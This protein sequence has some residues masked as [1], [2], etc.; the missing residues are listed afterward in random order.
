[1]HYITR[2]EHEKVIETHGVALQEM[3]NTFFSHHTERRAFLRNLELVL[4]RL[5]DVETNGYSPPKQNA[6]PSAKNEESEG[7]GTEQ[8]QRESASTRKRKK[9]KKKK[10]TQKAEYA[11]SKPT[12]VKADKI[13]QMPV[14]QAKKAEKDALVVALLGIGFVEEQI[15]AAVKACGGT[16]RATADDLV[17]WILGQDADGNIKGTEDDE[18]DATNE[19]QRRDVVESTPETVSKPAILPEE[20]MKSQVAAEEEAAA[21]QRLAAKREEQRRRNRAWNDREQSRQQVAAR[22][23]MK[24]A[25]ALPH[26]T[27]S[28]PVNS[29]GSAYPTQH[30][31]IS[32]EPSTGGLPGWLTGRET[33]TV[34][35]RETAPPKPK[36]LPVQSASAQ[37]TQLKPTKKF[38]T[39]KTNTLPQAPP[40]SAPKAV[41]QST[42]DTSYRPPESRTPLSSSDA[43]GLH[44]TGDD[45]RTVSSFGS[46][47]GLSVSSSSF[48]PATVPNLPSSK[49]IPPPGFMATP[50]SPQFQPQP[51][52]S[53]MNDAHMNPYSVSSNDEPGFSN[54]QRQLGEIRATAR[55]FVP[56]SFNPSM[57]DSGVMR[58]S[59]GAFLNSQAQSYPQLGSTTLEHNSIIGSHEVQSNF[60]TTLLPP[61]AGGP[62]GFPF[63]NKDSS[64]TVSKERMT[65]MI[66]MSADS[67]TLTTSKS[68]ISATEGPN[69][70]GIPLGFGMEMMQPVGTSSLLTSISTNVQA[71]ASS[72]WSGPQGVPTLGGLPTLTPMERNRR[73][74]DSH[75]TNVVGWGAGISTTLPP[76]GQGSIW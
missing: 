28:P 39:L 24:G 12:E 50:A 69:L 56:T 65:P 8:E 60:A 71:G 11:G 38:N 18:A 3:T 31:S 5:T 49:P 63:A 4:E 55:A 20:V 16:N 36:A 30:T 35:A 34:T 27:P 75:G 43:C 42:I 53:Q 45:E 67:G 59:S 61:G 7:T 70:A 32:N 6:A 57:S 66:P 73:E 62:N 2:E 10:Q 48:V 54:E 37:A 1:M 40:K 33:A 47:R 72:I 17:T 29:F 44:L 26:P 68:T 21:A 41:Y 19:T 46:H 76:G 52:E 15:I 23:R 58:P 64:I 13:Q 51:V 74:G 14:A 22:A 25:A 9:K